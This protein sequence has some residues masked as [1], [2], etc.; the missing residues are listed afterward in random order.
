MKTL[1]RKELI[2]LYDISVKEKVTSQTIVFEEG[3]FIDGLYIILSGK[4]MITKSVK[5]DGE[6]KTLEIE[7][8]EKGD[9]IGDYCFVF[10]EELPYSVV[11]IYPMRLLNIPLNHVKTNFSDDQLMSIVDS[12]RLYPNEE[13]IKRIYLEKIKWAQY[14]EDVTL[15]I[16][17]SKKIAVY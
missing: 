10:K 16:Q 17:N 1:S 13:D 4:A 2:H 15:D 9:M 8:I 11:S 5:I 7:R 12:V 6:V 14:S 3:D